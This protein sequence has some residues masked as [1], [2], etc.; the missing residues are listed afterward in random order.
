MIGISATLI[1]AGGW[2]RMLLLGACTAVVSGLLLVIVA[3][4]RL[5]AEP[6]EPLFA[7]VYEPGL[8]SGTAFG[9]G[10]LALPA[11]LLLYQAVRLGTA[12]R[13]R[14]LATLRLAGAT[15]GD[16]RVIGAIEVGV[17]AFAGSVAGIGVYA[18]LRALLGGAA[19][20]DVRLVPTTV[21]PAWWH[22]VLVVVGVGALGVAVGLLASG[23]VVVTPL[24]VARRALPPPPR[25]WGVLLLLVAVAVGAFGVLARV[26]RPATQAIALTAVALAVLGI[27]S[28]ASW[29]A[30]R[31]GRFVLARTTSPTL[32]LAAARVVA[33]PRAAGRAAAAVGGI[34]L[35]AGGAGGVVDDVNGQTGNDP[36]YWVSLLLVAAVLLVAL[37]MVVGTLAVHSAESLLDRKR[38]MSAL[39]VLG[40]SAEEIERAQFAE[41]ALA[42]M[43]VAAAGALIGSMVTSIPTLT[44]PLSFAILVATVAVTLGLVWL[45]ALLAVRA[46]RRWARQAVA[47]DNLR[48]T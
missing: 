5:P 44:A 40:A 29:F 36:F 30:Y 23:R 21:A 39:A 27:V 18:G 22:T 38:S 8:R 12:A 43:P 6:D 37:L 26:Q 14:R 20:R 48:T 31:A 45:A 1:R 25:P 7:L 33:E 28:L 15:P 10:M 13:E 9:T 17:P 16:V 32:T 46:T 42:A 34:A 3:Y 19:F 47:V 4:L 35:V 24:G 2:G 41:V 11:L